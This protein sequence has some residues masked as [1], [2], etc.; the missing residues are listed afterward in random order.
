MGDCSEAS[1]GCVDFVVTWQCVCAVCFPA[2]TVCLCHL[3]LCFCVVVLRYPCGALGSLMLT[4]HSFAVCCSCLCACVVLHCFGCWVDQRSHRRV[5]GC[6]C[7]C[8]VCK[9]L[10]GTYILAAP[11][12]PG[13]FVRTARSRVTSAYRLLRTVFI[14][15]YCHTCHQ[16]AH[17]FAHFSQCLLNEEEH[18]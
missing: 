8:R 13:V 2:R 1:K 16:H 6:T 15:R 18:S 10:A 9:N 14:S 17:C 12:L 5:E 4:R 3:L 11:T 7:F